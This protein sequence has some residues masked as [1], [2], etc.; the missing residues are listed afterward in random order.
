MAAN[1]QILEF[2]AN[3]KCVKFDGLSAH[4]N[5]RQSHNSVARSWGTSDQ[6]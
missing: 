3:M 4:K 2:F 6:N 5:Y 1:T